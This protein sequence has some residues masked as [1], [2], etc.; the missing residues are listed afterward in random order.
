MSAQSQ[1]LKIGRLALS[2]AA[3]ALL[4]TT[5]PGKAAEP[6]KIGLG[7]SLTGPL[8]ANGKMSLVAMQIWEDPTST[9]KG[10]LLGR[11]VKLVYYDDQSKPV[12]VPAHLLQ[13]ARCRQGRS[14]RQ[15]LCLDPDRRGD[16]GRDG[17][18]ETVR[19]SVRH[20]RQ[21]E[22]EYRKYFSMI[23]NGPTP[24]P[25]F[26][27]GF[28]KVAEAQNPKPQTI[29]HRRRGRRI[30]TAMPAKAPTKTPRPPASRSSTTRAIRRPRSTS[31]R[32]C[33]PS[34][35]AIRTCLVI[36][37]YPLDTVGHDQD[38]Q[39]NRLQAENVGRRHGRPAGHRV[40]DPARPAAQRRRQFRDLAA[41]QVDGVSRI[42]GAPEEISGTRRGRR[43]R[44]ARLLYAGVGLCRLQVLGQA[45]AATK[46]LN[47]DTLA[48]YM[49]QATFQTV[50]GE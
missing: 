24:K 48:D 27:R 3:A 49:P 6:I 8:A 28:F 32:S 17:E 25:A 50:V 11:P 16:A 37:S 22:F 42:D 7:M 46:S 41:G 13:A 18:E 26:T 19:Q 12:E 1:W 15:R 43:H 21:R 20:R 33:A 45:I 30:R 10:G 34:R 29:A 40:Q 9:R 38:D 23:P 39:R 47:D 2:A 35:R 4:F 14:D 31:R 36:C 5:M 44:S